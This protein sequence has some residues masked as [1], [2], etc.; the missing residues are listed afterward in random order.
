MITTIGPLSAHEVARHLGVHV[1][2]V[3]RIPAYELPFFRFGTRGDRKYLLEHVERY[4]AKRIV[5]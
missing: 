3:K 2:T 1:N 5:K 4:I